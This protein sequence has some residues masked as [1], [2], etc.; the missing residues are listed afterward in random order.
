MTTDLAIW[1]L[2][3]IAVVAAN[4]P[5]LSDRLLFVKELPGG[6][7]LWLRLLEWL[8][9]Y[10]VVGAVA[11]GLERKTLGDIHPQGWEFYTVTLC[12]FLVFA[13]PGFLY[14]YDLKHHLDRA[15]RRN[16]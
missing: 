14:R 4:L 6:K 5:W 1:L 15:R 16:A 13:L 11:L 10:L 8:L 3:A 7:P 2:L 12:L 9:L